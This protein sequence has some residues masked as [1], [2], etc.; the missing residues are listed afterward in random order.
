[1]AAKRKNPSPGGGNSNGPAKKKRVHARSK[2]SV[3]DPS[4][5]PPRAIEGI[6]RAVLASIDTGKRNVFR[7]LK[8]VRGFENRK[9]LRRIKSAR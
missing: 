9:L 3:I 1:M 2:P 4:L 7:A 8:K 6:H 5:L